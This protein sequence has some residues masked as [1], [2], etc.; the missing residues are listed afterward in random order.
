MNDRVTVATSKGALRGFRRTA[1]GPVHFRGIPFA[2]TTAGEN[3]WKPP[4]PVEAWEGE[5]DCAQY[6]EACLQ[7]E[8]GMSKHLG[9]APS[10]GD[11]GKMGDDCLNLNVVT[12]DPTA[13][14]R[15]LLPV[16]VWTIVVLVP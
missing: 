2:A 1:G 11:I 6:G 10:G 8:K 3:R 7:N 9:G 14:G 16:M 13:S 4:Q 12:P 15:G 5:R